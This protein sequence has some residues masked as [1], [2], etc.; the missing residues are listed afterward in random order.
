M[1]GFFIARVEL[2]VGDAGPSAHALELAGTED[3]PVTHRVLVFESPRQ[4]V[5]DDLHVCVCVG[6]EALTRRD[7]ILVDHAERAE[8][9]VRWV[10]VIREGEGVT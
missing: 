4:N 3:L 7:P 6:A 10:V 2:T 1:R 5:G 8:A 9:R